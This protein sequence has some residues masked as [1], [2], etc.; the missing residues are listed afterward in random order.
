MERLEVA[1][2]GNHATIW[3]SGKS[4]MTEMCLMARMLA[5]RYLRLG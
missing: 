3:A 4:A 2:L 5:W 1:D